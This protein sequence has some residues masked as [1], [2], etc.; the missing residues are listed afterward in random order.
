MGAMRVFP[1]RTMT[2][3]AGT[4][5]QGH[6]TLQPGERMVLRNILFNRYRDG[7]MVETREY[8]VQVLG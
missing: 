6:P 8:G 7:K 1:D 5:A 4:A 3:W 2:V